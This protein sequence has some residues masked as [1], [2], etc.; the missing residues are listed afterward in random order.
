MSENSICGYATVISNMIFFS[1]VKHHGAL[2]HCTELHPCW[3]TKETRAGNPPRLQPAVQA[4]SHIVFTFAASN[5]PPNNDY[6]V[7][8]ENKTLFIIGFGWFLL[9]ITQPDVILMSVW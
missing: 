3:Q 7:E 5:I 1:N 4:D 2:N 6:Q 8:G 9:K